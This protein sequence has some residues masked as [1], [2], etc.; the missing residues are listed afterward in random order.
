[1]DNIN[2]PIA[3]KHTGD[4]DIETGTTYT[5]FN[6]TFKLFIMLILLVVIG[7]FFFTSIVRTTETIFAVDKLPYHICWILFIVFVIIFILLEKFVVKKPFRAF[8]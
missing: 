4:K 3:K 6:T 1:M 8:Y 7:Q 2:R 5:S